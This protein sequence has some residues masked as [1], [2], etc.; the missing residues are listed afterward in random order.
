MFHLFLA[1]NAWTDFREGLVYDVF[2][3]ILLLAAAV[4]TGFRFN[5]P[6][7]GGCL[8][9]LGLI[10][11]L[12]RDEKWL[13]RG[14]YLILLSVSLKAGSSLPLVLLLTSC[15]ALIGL[16]IRKQR[17]IPLVPFLFL[18]FVLT[19]LSGLTKLIS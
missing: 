5:D 13:G 3:S 14:D 10:L 11:V 4:E 18:G 16:G 19:E 1:I 2:S 17:T 15:T 6:Y 12:D 8:L 9:V 7:F